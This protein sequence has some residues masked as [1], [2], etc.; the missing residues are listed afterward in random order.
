RYPMNACH[1]PCVHFG[2][3]IRT[4]PPLCISGLA[5]GHAHD[6]APARWDVLQSHR[7]LHFGQPPLRHLYVLRINLDAHR[8]PTETFGNEQ[9]RA[10][11]SEGVEDNALAGT[12]VIGARA[13]GLPT[14]KP[15]RATD[16]TSTSSGSFC[17]F[18]S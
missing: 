4:T 7:Q 5:H 1:S 11:A 15:N 3:P 12:V 18:S 17:S 8:L 9:S 10:T 6:A 14:L 2:S 13:G 16:K